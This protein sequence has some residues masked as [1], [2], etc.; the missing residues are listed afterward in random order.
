MEAPRVDGQR[1]KINVSG[2]TVNGEKSPSFKVLPPSTKYFSSSSMS[3]L[4]ATGHAA[5]VPMPR[6]RPPRAEVM[7]PRTVRMPC[8]AF[9]PSMSSGEVSGGRSR[10][11]S[12]ASAGASVSSRDNKPLPQA[13]PGEGGQRTAGGLGAALSAAASELRVQ[14]AVELLGLHF[15]KRSSLVSVPPS[16]TRATAILSAAAAGVRAVGLQHV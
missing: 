2:R 8:A 15:Q 5:G 4:A 16:S 1:L 13:C 11:F 7:P 10:T 6:A 12:P 9:M 3:M 14:Q